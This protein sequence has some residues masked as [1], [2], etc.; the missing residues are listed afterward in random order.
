MPPAY[1]MYGH[2]PDIRCMAAYHLGYHYRKGKGVQ[3]NKAKALEYFLHAAENE[4]IYQVYAMRIVGEMY[5]IT[6]CIICSHLPT[7]IM[8]SLHRC[9][10][11]RKILILRRIILSN[12]EYIYP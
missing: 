1:A 10:A 3:L 6:C 8:C 12:V 4:G 11:E 9:V 5:H 2:R 7:G